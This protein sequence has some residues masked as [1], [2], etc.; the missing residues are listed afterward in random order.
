M[1]TMKLVTAGFLLAIAACAGQHA[2]R[3]EDEATRGGKALVVRTSIPLGLREALGDARAR[4]PFL[5]PG[6]RMA[7][8]WST[9]HGTL[10]AAL[11]ITKTAES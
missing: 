7:L 6:W 1:A 9:T 2:A 11:A 10:H 8:A 3:L 5:A 4:L